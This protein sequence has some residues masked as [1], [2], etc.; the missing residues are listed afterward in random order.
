MRTT[1]VLILHF[2]L[3]N[4]NVFEIASEI[5]MFDFY[6]INFDFWKFCDGL[7]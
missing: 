5:A 1:Y 6:R 2:V 7:T 3:H 4:K